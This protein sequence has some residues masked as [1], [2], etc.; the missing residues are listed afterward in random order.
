MNMPECHGACSAA[1]QRGR[2]LAVAL[3]VPRAFRRRLFLLADAYWM[4]TKPC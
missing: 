4:I 1:G 2:Q 3:G